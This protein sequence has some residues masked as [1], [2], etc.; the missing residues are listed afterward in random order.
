VQKYSVTWDHAADQVNY[1]E[2]ATLVVNPDDQWLLAQ[3]II[4]INP[5]YVGAAAQVMRQ[6]MQ[7]Q[8]QS[9]TPSA[10]FT[11]LNEQL[12]TAGLVGAQ[13]GRGKTPTRSQA[14]LVFPLPPH[15]M[16]SRLPLA[17]RKSVGCN[18][19]GLLVAGLLV[20]T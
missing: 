9:A 14:L 10:D 3:P 7:Q 1:N 12:L 13:V 18:L 2:I 16:A 4:G 20:A 19:G 5:F 6:V 17:A 15:Q 11:L 8:A